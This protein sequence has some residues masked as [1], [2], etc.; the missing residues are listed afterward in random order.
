MEQS[1]FKYYIDFYKNEQFENQNFSTIDWVDTDT[2]MEMCKFADTINKKYKCLLSIPF[3]LI[4]GMDFMSET[5]ECS[6]CPV[7]EKYFNEFEEFLIRKAKV[8]K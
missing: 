2:C 4:A 7:R 6:S 1:D 8:Y 5:I 3:L